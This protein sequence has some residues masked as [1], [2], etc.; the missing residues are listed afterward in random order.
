MPN[1]VEN[2]LTLEGPAQEIMD[3]LHTVLDNEN[4]DKIVDFNKV[5]PMPEDLDIT[6]GSKTIKGL[7]AYTAFVDVGGLEKLYQENPKP[8]I[9][10][11]QVETYRREHPEVTPE[12]WELGKRAYENKRQYGFTDWYDWRIANWGTKWVGCDAKL[13]SANT[14]RF[15]TAWNAPHPIVEEIARRHPDFYITHKWADENLGS[16]LGEREYEGGELAFENAI[17][18]ELAAKNFALNVWKYEPSDVSLALNNAGTRYIHTEEDVYDVVELFNAPALFVNERLTEADIPQGMYC[19]HLR[20]SDD[21]SRFAAIEPTVTVNYGGTV[22]TKAPLNF[23][24][25]GYIPLTDETTPNFTGRKATFG[26]FMRDDP[27][28]ESV[29]QPTAKPR[30]GPHL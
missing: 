2:I 25:K 13:D 9:P 29:L 3:F 24:E 14:L 12:E 20:E 17:M 23:G 10:P 16:N 4:H 28:A 15:M 6:A 8:D 27:I 30:R 22:V 18:S 5:I 21:G 19:Y 7:R 1:Y 11:K 26:E